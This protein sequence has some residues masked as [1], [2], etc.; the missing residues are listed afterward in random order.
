MLKREGL[1]FTLS[2]KAE[3]LSTNVSRWIDV[4]AGASYFF[5]EIASKVIT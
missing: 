3:K 5:N 1:A 2:D 4:V